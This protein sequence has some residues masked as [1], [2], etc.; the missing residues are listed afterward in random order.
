[1]VKV[2]VRTA[3]RTQQDWQPTQQR[4]QRPTTSLS[5]HSQQLNQLQL[6]YC[7]NGVV[8][9]S[10]CSNDVIERPLSALHIADGVRS[11]SA[12]TLDHC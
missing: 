12:I 11:K 5:S 4:Q 10:P 7:N 2:E 9:S 1:M 8:H 3:T 6:N